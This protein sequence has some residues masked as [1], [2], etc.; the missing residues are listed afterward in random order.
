[1]VTL[2]VM[3]GCAVWGWM[4]WMRRMVTTAAAVGASAARDGWEERNFGTVAQ[5]AGFI[6]HDL[7]ERGAHGTVAG[8]G[9]GMGSAA[10]QQFIAQRTQGSGLGLHGFAAGA[11]GFADGG[12]VSDGDLHG[13]ED[14]DW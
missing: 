14:G 11:Q 13:S 6:G 5:G 12:K 9:L 1:M 10:C 3:V 2:G 7:V 8:Q 4:G